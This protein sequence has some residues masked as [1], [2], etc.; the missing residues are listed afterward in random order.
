MVVDIAMGKIILLAAGLTIHIKIM[1]VCQTLEVLQDV[2][3]IFVPE[4]LSIDIP[5]VA[6]RTLPILKSK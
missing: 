6:S 5:V 1:F 2:L 4:G 3:K